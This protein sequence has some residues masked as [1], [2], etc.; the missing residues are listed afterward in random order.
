MLLSNLVTTSTA[1][2]AVSSRLSKINELAA[3]LSQVTPDEVAPVIAYLSGT[4]RQG[5]IGIGGAIV[6]EARNTLPG[7]DATL[8]IE[9][10]DRAF[11]TMAGISGPGATRRRTETLRDL[12]GRATEQEQ[13]FLVRLLFGELRQGALEGVLIEAVAKAARA[14]AARVRRATMLAGDLAP[15]A[16]AALGGGPDALDAFGLRVLQPVQPM[17][18]DSAE[19]VESAVADLGDASLEY[20][21]DGARIQVHKAGDEIV[22]FSRALRPVTPAVPEVIEAVRALPARELILDGEVL[23]FRPDGTPRPFQETMRRFGRRLEVDTLRKELPLTPIF[24]DLLHRDGHDLLDAPQ[25]E[26][27]A[28]LSEISPPS[29]VVPHRL[30][31]S[32]QG[33][34]A[35]LD[36]ALAHGHEGLMAKGRDAPY[37]AGSRGSSWLKVKA[38]RT[39]DLVVLAAEWG[40]GRR[41]GWLS[42]LHLGARDPEHGGFVMLGKTFK[43]LTDAMLAW[44]T[45]RLLSL[46]IGRDSYVVHVKPALVVEIAFNDIQVSPQYPGGVAL[47]FARVKR[48]R[49]DKPASEADTIG[50]VRQMHAA[51]SRQGEA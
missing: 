44:Q 30:S 36:E 8:T 29:L 24:F 18:A 40:S 5:R 14:P 16:R 7:R 22:V 25:A 1:V 45:E 35:F 17:L 34:R 3:L 13:D 19:D 31:P 39:L 37:A 26:R 49:E 23:A 51:L 46:E 32:A 11:A 43:G 47:R 27:F 10:V 12:L 20:K 15:V 21:M 6:S 50:T 38:V 2:A 33:A 28:M 48:Y 42:N 4:P 9:D 41:Q